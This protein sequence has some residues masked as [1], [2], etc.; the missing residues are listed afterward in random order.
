MRSIS[1]VSLKPESFV[2]SKKRTST[3]KETENDSN[4]FQKSEIAKTDSLDLTEGSI[5]K[6]LESTNPQQY[7]HYSPKKISSRI[8][9]SDFWSGKMKSNF[10]KLIKQAEN[11]TATEILSQRSSNNRMPPIDERF[12][13][14]NHLYKNACT[15]KVAA[16]PYSITIDKIITEC[17]SV[18]VI[19]KRFNERLFD[20]KKCIDREV[21]FIERRLTQIE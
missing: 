18:K 13:R 10:Q 7:F 11:F 19:N 6:K 20:S 8:H 3:Y 9:C 14:S 4:S 5:Q 21:N 12:L 15:P 1:L 16:L 2:R 17:K